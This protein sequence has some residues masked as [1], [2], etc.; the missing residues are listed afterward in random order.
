[1]PGKS[2]VWRVTEESDTFATP[3][4]DEQTSRTLTHWTFMESLPL[5]RTG[6]SQTRK[7]WSL[8]SK[9]NSQSLTQTRTRN[10]QGTDYSSTIVENM[11]GHEPLPGS[12]KRSVGPTASS[13][14]H[15]R[16]RCSPPGTSQAFDHCAWVGTKKL[17]RTL[18]PQ[19]AA[20]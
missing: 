6:P 19:R 1:M 5:P 13:L 11:T 15:T 8:W 9:A 3:L 7:T 4:V 16:A 20:P 12:P 17:G 18:W 14:S 10:W 2:S